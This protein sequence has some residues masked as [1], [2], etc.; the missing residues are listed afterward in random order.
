MNPHSFFGIWKYLTIKEDSPDSA[1]YELTA[2]Q[3]FE[4]VRQNYRGIES[5]AVEVSKQIPKLKVSNAY[6]AL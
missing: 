2:G 6:S 1:T 4:P 5:R 3:L